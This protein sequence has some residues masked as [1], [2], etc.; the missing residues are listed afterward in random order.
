MRRLA[1]WFSLA[2]GLYATQAPCL[3]Q[4]QPVVRREGEYT[5]VRPGQPSPE[6]K[7]RPLRK[8]TLSW[9]GFQ[10]K[11][12]GAEVFLQSPSKLEVQQRLEGSTLI[13][14]LTGLSGLVANARRPIDTRFFDNPL[15]RIAAKTVRHKRKRGVEVRIWFKNPKQAKQGALR[16][17]TEADGLFYA[18]LSFPEGAED[19]SEPELRNEVE[20]AS[21]TEFKEE[22][23]SKT[24]DEP[25]LEP[26]AT[27]DG[28]AAK[29][30]STAKPKTQT[31]AKAKAKPAAQPKVETETAP[32]GPQ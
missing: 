27:E 9:I 6:H 7:R 30:K 18:Y 31:K 5:G 16:L 10:P 17:A 15:A 23:A 28:P 12:G 20:P 3:A 26:T 21:K 13:V 19:A 25:Q 29:P 32:S 11:D 24:E 2:L 14:H 1:C 4:A 8:G 22:P